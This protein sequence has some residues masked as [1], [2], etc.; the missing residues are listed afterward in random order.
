MSRTA[1]NFL[2][3]FSEVENVDEALWCVA[4][5]VIWMMHFWVQNTA[6][7]S[8][9]EYMNVSLATLQLLQLRVKIQGLTTNISLHSHSDWKLKWTNLLMGC[10]TLSGGGP[11][12]VSH[13]EGCV[14]RRSHLKGA[15]VIES[16]FRKASR[17]LRMQPSNA[18]FFHRNSEDASG[19]SFTATDYPK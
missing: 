8:Q 19:V 18:S 17:T 16:H 14:L 7:C 5:C 1:A 15:Y 2:V 9:T 10:R 4:V 3:F 6:A 12:A 13:L 11:M